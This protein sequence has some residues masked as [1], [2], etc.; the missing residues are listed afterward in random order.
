[1]CSGRGGW[2]RVAQRW[3][4]GARHAKRSG[5]NRGLKCQMS[6]ASLSF[7][8]LT[9]CLE[10]ERGRGPVMRLKG[11][12]ARNASQRDQLRDCQVQLQTGQPP[13]PLLRSR[14][15]RKEGLVLLIRRRVITHTNLSSDLTDFGPVEECQESGPFLGKGKAGRESEVEGAERSAYTRFGNSRPIWPGGHRFRRLA[16]R[17]RCPPRGGRQREAAGREGAC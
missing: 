15:S 16:T 3:R 12:R 1:M 17:S 11:R 8:K 5:L 9:I 2:H 6:V 4:W 14:R 10:A 7:T 13:A